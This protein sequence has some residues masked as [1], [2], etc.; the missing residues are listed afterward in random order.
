MIEKTVTWKAFSALI[1]ICLLAGCAGASGG[2]RAGAVSAA[3][4]AQAPAA[5]EPGS[6][7]WKRYFEAL[8][9]NAKT[10]SDTLML[11]FTAEPCEPCDTMRKWTL[12]DERVAR[13]VRSFAPVRIRGDIEVQPMRKF[14]IRTFPTIIFFSRTDG[15][16]DRK[17]GFRDADFML[18][19][20]ERV[21]E[22]K[23]TIA[24]LEEAL[25]LD[26]TDVD[27]MLGLARNYLDAGR[28]DKALDLTRK[29]EE[30]A[31]ES[32]SALALKGLRLLSERKIDE[33]EAA[34]DAALEADPANKQ[35]RRLKIEILLGRA[36]AAL[37][38]GDAAGAM[39]RLSTVLR[40]DA[41]N[42]DALI[43]AG[44]ALSRMG[45][46]PGA[47]EKLERA[48]E[49]KPE[50]P[51]PHESLGRSHEAA[52]DEAAAEAAYLRAVEIEPRYEPPYFRL[53]EMYERQ[54]RRADM[55]EI[56]EKA[57]PLSPSGAHNEIA[58]LMATSEH[59]DIRDPE[60]AIEHA[61]IAIELEPHAWYIDTLAEAYYAVGRYDTA[62]AVIREAI[63]KRPDDLEYYVEQLE[64][65]QASKAAAAAPPAKEPPSE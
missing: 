9:P 8:G 24:A 56:Y 31:P 43:G 49:V 53:I 19:W 45:D 35:A 44:R 42:F 64:K 16:I 63:A 48:A 34:I 21:K 6:I 25:K 36:D 38:K 12:A 2:V 33:A 17:I 57:L 60:A 47:L 1:A 28:I 20:I 29:A 10:R 3:A 61:N 7:P 15:E 58:W 37:L 14:G 39:E 5:S 62:I 50:S 52:G 30:I 55:M 22:N 11:Y 18:E 59:A 32:A 40:I 27:A 4:S 26:A 13:A 65:F 23:G 46:Y 41:D 51:L 54:D